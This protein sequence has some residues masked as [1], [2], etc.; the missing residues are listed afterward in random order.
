MK[1]ILFIVLCAMMFLAGCNYI[2]P[3]ITKGGEVGINKIDKVKTPSSSGGYFEITIEP[4]S[5]EGGN[6]ND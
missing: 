2:L 3:S 1:K 4:I 6:K 5:I